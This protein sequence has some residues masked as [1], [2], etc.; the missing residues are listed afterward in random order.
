MTRSLALAGGLAALLS[1]CA[2]APCLASADPAI[3]VPW[4][5]ALIAAA[6][7]L[8]AF[9]VPLVITAATAALARIAG[10]VRVL[11]TASLVERLVR[12]VADY[13]VNAVAGAV[14]GRTLAVPVGSMVI[15]QAVQRALDQAPGWLVR[16]AGGIEG[17]AEKVFRALPLDAEATA[18]NT[19]APA[20]DA[21][22]ARTPP[23]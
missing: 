13:A 6:Q 22:K 8:T 11:I 16:A 19:L 5:D 1:S 18:G 14:R 9:L 21:V 3:L 17:L 7:G 20:I 4:G 12:N 10:P 15:A 2:A 23:A